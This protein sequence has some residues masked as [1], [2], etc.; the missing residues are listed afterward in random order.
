MTIVKS[1]RRKL[2]VAAVLAAMM[3]FVYTQYKGALV[4]RF[5][6]LFW[7]PV[8]ADTF[9]LPD[10]ISLALRDP[11]PTATP[12]ALR[13]E[14]I[15]KGFEVGELPVLVDGAEADRILV[16]RIDPAYFRFSVEN[17]PSGSKHLDD[18]MSETG[19]ALIVNAGYYSRTGEPATPVVSHGRLIGPAQYDSK[20][21]AFVFAGTAAGIRDLAQEDWRTALAQTET[22][23]V[24]YPLLLAPGGS[25]ARTPK[26]SGWLAN[27]SFIGE[28]RSGHVIIGTTKSA[29]FALD[30]LAE[31]LKASPLKLTAALNLDGGP[32]ACQ[33]TK[34]G[35]FDRRTY[36]RWELQ[37]E[38]GKPKVLP[39]WLLQTAPMPLVLAVFP[40]R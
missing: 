9:W 30:R 3:L 10:S 5:G 18:W 39:P 32:V 24:S 25:T 17:D 29:F 21:G 40:R 31:F 4:V 22:A 38:N 16:A 12:G 2:I 37:I 15:G 8:T 35:R 34:L 14:E 7:L 23:I 1:R 33:G 28:D 11:A 6:G 19:A 27:R 36:G 13:W 20:H 26:G